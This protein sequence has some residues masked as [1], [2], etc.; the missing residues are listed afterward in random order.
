MAMGFFLWNRAF[1]ALPAL[2]APAED[3]PWEVKKP[4]PVERSEVAA[5]ALDDRVYVIG[6]FLKDG[7]ADLVEE[8]DP[9]DDRWREKAPLPRPLHHTAAAAVNNMVY[10]IGG[11]SMTAL[12]AND[13]NIPSSMVYAYAALK[14]GIPYANGAPNLTV[15]IPALMDLAQKNGCPIVG[16]DFKTGQTLIKTIIAPGLKA[17]LIGINGWYST[18]ILGNRDGEVLDDPA[19]TPGRVTPATLHVGEER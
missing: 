13:V 14:E 2:M 17:R 3:G 1:L 9:A 6:G 15:D 12:V 10:V 18:N 11:F 8:Y 16:K 4:A 7:I 19:G 5:A